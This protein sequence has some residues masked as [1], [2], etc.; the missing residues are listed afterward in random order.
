MTDINS[1]EFEHEVVL[2]RTPRETFAWCVEHFGPRWNPID[3][4]TGQWTVFWTGPDD[5]YRYLFFDEKDATMFM[6][7]WA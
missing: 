4:R 7:K 1:H 2:K 3:N 6:L 5:H